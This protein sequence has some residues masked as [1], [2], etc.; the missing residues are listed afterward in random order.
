MALTRDNDSALAAL[1]KLAADL[2]TQQSSSPLKRLSGPS[3]SPAVVPITVIAAY[4]QMMKG[5]YP[6]SRSDYESQQSRT[7][8]A[9][10]TVRAAEM[11]YVS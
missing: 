2:K 6:C 4:Q 11:M 9:L 7:L 8:K 3:T 1:Q 10:K 5:E